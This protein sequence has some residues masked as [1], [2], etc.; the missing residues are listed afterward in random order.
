[1]FLEKRFKI[2]LFSLSF[3]FLISPSFAFADYINQKVV[4]FVDS[5][6]DASGRS[7]VSTTL[8]K[9]TSQLY[10]YID[11]S[12]WDS[13]N[14]DKQN[15]VDTALSSLANEFNYTIYPLL[16]SNFGQEP[17]PGIDKDKRITILIHPMIEEAGGYFNSGDGYS[18]L[19]NPRSNEREMVYLNS[20]QIDKSYTKSLLAHEF[21]HLIT[22]NQK[23]ILRGITEETWLNEARADYTSTFLGYDDP[24]DGSNLQ[25]RV[26]NFLDRSYDSL[27][28]WQN[29]PFDYGVINLF[30]QYLVDHYGVKILVDSLQS[31]KV[32][33][34]SI[35]EALSKNGY[36]EDFSQIF[37]DWTIAVF[38]NDCQISENYCFKNKSLNNFHVI[39]SGN[40]LPLAGKSTLT[41]TQTTK[42]WSGN[43]YKFVGGWDTL[44]IKF[45]GDPKN[46]FKVPYITQDSFGNWQVA[47]F[48][49]NKD[50]HGEILIPEFRTKIISITII[51]SIQTKISGFDNSE[52][53]FSFSWTA[54]VG[55]K[56]AEEEEV[57]LV[58][59]LQAQIEE[60]K[61]QI[62]EVQ[63]KISAILAKKELSS[64]SCRKLENN[65]YYGMM[66]NSEVRCLQ[67]F[68][69][70]QG[71]EIYPEGLITGN[72]LSL[73]QVALIRF[74]E[75][76][77]DEIL[78]P[79]NLEKGT[80]YVGQ[81]TRAKINELLGK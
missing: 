3:L 81:M 57:E 1:M 29:K 51:P 38:V 26:K 72:F 74:Q 12:W 41:V 71:P 4:F 44:K 37:T 39:P 70:I 77:S 78:K 58:K 67:E 14:S 62:A 25:K 80:G 60:L 43:W 46:L 16:T 40:F 20:Q 65:L 69:K 10:F 13:L 61:K 47:F 53:S 15:V 5:T 75:K 50:Q 59:N 2:I 27:T 7:Q 18:K 22:F 33:I 76:Y 23:D 19:Q 24:Y 49:L 28:E 55:E 66:E 56:T 35:N 64:F 21:M 11:D 63:A 68:L 30:T 42:N 9:I 54:S 36:S 45:S 6:Y 17:K 8:K 34:P 31:S 52:P 48:E 32:G 79:L 73:T